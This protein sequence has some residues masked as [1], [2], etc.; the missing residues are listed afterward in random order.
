MSAKLRGK[1]TH[2]ASVSKKHVVHSQQVTLAFILLVLQFQLLQWHNL[3]TVVS[4]HP[5]VLGTGWTA[6]SRH[7]ISL[8]TDFETEIA[9]FP[10]SP[11]VTKT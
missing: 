4:H 11:S 6:F 1:K 10:R 8:V 5:L 3:S 7:I 2:N 9:V